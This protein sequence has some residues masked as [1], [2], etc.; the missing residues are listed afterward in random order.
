MTDQVMWTLTRKQS[1][2]IL[3]MT[4]TYFNTT[5]DDLVAVLVKNQPWVSVSWVN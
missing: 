1:T 5:I 3:K 2:F 4:F